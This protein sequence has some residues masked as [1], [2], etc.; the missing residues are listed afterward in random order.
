M[1]AR[2]PQTAAL[3]FS[4]RYPR[5][6]FY[7]YFFA[8][9][10][11][12]A[13]RGTFHAPRG[14]NMKDARKKNIA[15]AGEAPNGPTHASPAIP[16]GSTQSATTPQST[17]QPTSS[18]GS[19]DYGTA[20]KEGRASIGRH[21]RKCTVCHHPQRQGIEQEYLR[22][23][24]PAAIAREFGL[25]GPTTIYRHVHA[26]GIFTRR[27][28]RLRLALDPLIEQ[29]TEVNVTARAILSAIKTPANLNNARKW[30]G[31]P[32]VWIARGVNRFA[33]SEINAA[34]ADELQDLS[35]RE[36]AESKP[37]ATS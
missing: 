25:T 10:S 2:K 26:T 36:S 3:T 11:V 16:N 15:T 37:D 13:S 28:A 27:R 22:W 8:G 19:M 7:E 12:S 23:R 35:N 17:G 20:P 14:R 31:R 33:R 1:L 29:V 5:P 21:Q 30:I 6:Y 9:E 32:R 34:I 18:A 4:N 24:S